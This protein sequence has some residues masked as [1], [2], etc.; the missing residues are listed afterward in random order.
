MSM[1]NRIT[2]D[3]L[4]GMPVGEISG[5]P[6]E[7]L[8]LL[9]DDLAEERARLKR[10]DDWLNGALALRYGER[11]RA[12][13]HALGKD[14]GTVRIE[15]AEGFVAICDLPKKPEYDQGKLRAAVETI[16]SWGSNPDDYI[17]IEIKVSETRY[18]AWPPEIR[19]LFEPARTLRVG[20]PGFRLERPKPR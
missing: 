19:R 20:K 18:G 6:V 3:D 12:L 15:E 10:L 16:R 4:M 7:Q 13:R 1:N 5:L 11:A 17:G 2:L 9:L 14:A 8:A